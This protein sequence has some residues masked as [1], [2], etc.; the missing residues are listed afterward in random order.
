MLAALLMT[1]D[2]VKLTRSS[3]ILDALRASRDAR[4][5]PVVDGDD[6]VLGVITARSLLAALLHGSRP[7]GLRNLASA[8]PALKDFIDNIN[9]LE[10]RGVCDL[11]DKDYASVD[12]ETPSMKVAA[13][14]TDPE[15]RV[16]GV[17][18]VD[19]QRRVLGVITV[20][21]MLKRLCEYAEKN[22]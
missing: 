21:D 14:F 19:S 6:K 10:S 7:G 11:I 8:V 17:L 22:C 15:K 3:T 4:L 16:E 20:T 5:I 18:V 2:V 13:L 12:P 9:G 1:T